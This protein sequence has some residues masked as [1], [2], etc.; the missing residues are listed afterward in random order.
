M[1]G[2]QFI[3]SWCKPN[4]RWCGPLLTQ[5]VLNLIPHFL[6]CNIAIYRRQHSLVYGIGLL[7]DDNIMLSSVY[8]YMQHSWVDSIHWYIHMITLLSTADSIHWYN[9]MTKLLSTGQ[10]SFMLSTVDK[11]HRYIQ[12]ITL[13]S[14]VDK[15]YRLFKLYRKTCTVTQI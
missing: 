3:V 2:V 4:T 6:Q 10:I 8:R 14:T 11:V 5:R 1:I 12:M 15:C 9:Q 13:L 7:T